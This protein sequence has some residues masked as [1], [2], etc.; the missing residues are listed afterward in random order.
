MRYIFIF[1]EPEWTEA[2]LE[3]GFRI[4][5]YYYFE[6]KG[7]V[8]QGNQTYQPNL[9]PKHAFPEQVFP[10]LLVDVGTAVGFGRY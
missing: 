4:I 1:R 3:S 6:N 10:I 7:V 9:P 2:M 5:G 8:K